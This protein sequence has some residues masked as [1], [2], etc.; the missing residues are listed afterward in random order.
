MSKITVG[1]LLEV[2]EEAF[3]AGWTSHSE[4]P[5]VDPDEAFKAWWE[6]EEAK[7]LKS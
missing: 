4:T 7:I 2:W 6:A 1:K 3:K 5:W